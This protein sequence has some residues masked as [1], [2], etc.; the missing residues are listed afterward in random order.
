MKDSVCCLVVSRLTLVLLSSRRYF[1]YFCP[2]TESSHAASVASNDTVFTT[3]MA[4]LV[5]EAVTTDGS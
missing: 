2:S 3:R 4:G 1:A 5:V